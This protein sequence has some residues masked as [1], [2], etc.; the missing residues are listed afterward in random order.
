MNKNEIIYKELSYKTVGL[1]M[2]VHRK[3][4]CGFLEKVYENSMMVLFKREG[5]SAKQQVPVRV[6]FEGEQVGYYISDILVD[7]K[8]IIELKAVSSLIDEHK[9]QVLN[10]LKATNLHLAILINFG[11][12]SLQY[13]RVVN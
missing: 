3:L 2:E 8:I 6:H 5:I 10:Y 13:E 4:G 7:N 12:K 11:N 1:A 9:A